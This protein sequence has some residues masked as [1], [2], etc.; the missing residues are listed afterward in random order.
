R[1]TSLSTL[2]H[3]RGQSGVQ[4]QG[5]RQAHQAVPARGRYHPGLRVAGVD[6]RS[7]GDQE[8]LSQ[9]RTP[10]RYRAS[11]QHQSVR[12]NLVAIAGISSY[13]PPGRGV[14]AD[15]EAGWDTAF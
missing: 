2:A 3:A 15:V 12:R 9:S 1:W 6:L 11:L 14:V 7:A 5:P 13:R 8:R 10:R 4:K